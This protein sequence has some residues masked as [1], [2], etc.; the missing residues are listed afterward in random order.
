VLDDPDWWAGKSRFTGTYGNFPSA[1]VEVMY[2]RTVHSDKIRSVGSK[3]GGGEGR[4]SGRDQEE[5]YADPILPDHAPSPTHETGDVQEEILRLLRE[6]NENA[7]GKRPLPDPKVKP[8][9]PR[10][11]NRNPTYAESEIDTIRPEDS[12]SMVGVDQPP[13]QAP[14]IFGVMNVPQFHSQQQQQQH[15][16]YAQNGM[17]M[18][19]LPPRPMPALP[20]QQQHMSRPGERL[21][22]F[23][24]NAIPFPQ[25][26]RSQG[27][28]VPQNILPP[29][30]A[31][32][33][34]MQR[35]DSPP[36][37]ALQPFGSGAR[38]ANTVAQNNSHAN[39]AYAQQNQQWQVQSRL[40]AGAS[41][42]AFASEI[43][44]HTQIP[45]NRMQM[46]PLPVP[47]QPGVYMVPSHSQPPPRAPAPS[48]RPAPQSTMAYMN[49]APLPSNSAPDASMHKPSNPITP[50][51]LPDHSQEEA[52]LQL[53]YT[54]SFDQAS[55][56][57]QHSQ[58]PP[59]PPK[60][61]NNLQIMRPPTQR[62]FSL[63]PG[64]PYMQQNVQRVDV[65]VFGSG[66]FYP[67]PML[68][69]MHTHQR[70]GSLPPMAPPPYNNYPAPPMSMS[71]MAYASSIGPQSSYASQ[72]VILQQPPPSQQGK[73]EEPPQEK[74]P[75][76]PSSN[77]VP[78]IVPRIDGKGPFEVIEQCK[79]VKDAQAV[80]INFLAVDF[81]SV[82]KYARTLKGMD[83]SSPDSFAQK[84]VT[85][86]FKSDLE[87]V[88]CIF[89]WMAESI[90][91]DLK[92][93]KKAHS[94]FG[95]GN[96]GVKESKDKGMEEE[97]AL[98]VL[99]KRKCKRDGWAN[100]F[101]SI[102][103]TAGIKSSLVHGFVKGSKDDLENNQAHEANHSWNVGMHFV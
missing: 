4:R 93:D 60:P 52:S 51:D 50:N 45:S 54:K 48:Y 97:S 79:N 85:A 84:H 22:N 76:G 33:H 102:A 42:A 67:N 41:P 47:Q 99:R 18:P 75:A 94:W 17:M 53:P 32:K 10:P 29:P 95:F 73:S 20:Q 26:T 68:H 23:E 34:A 3:G 81:G 56:H 57:S 7:D 80:G 83:F 86:R 38:N 74:Q 88:R 98:N 15:M 92:P 101:Q 69:A 66:Q 77:G 49:A 12:I 59:T 96:G 91:W 62:P 21:R 28:A 61:P 36:I 39:S 19:V 9:P 46:R 64:E 63:P 25:P 8:P 43:H 24:M 100:L 78:W 13:P 6:S 44:A 40:L 71:A 65:P 30:G 70:Q 82:D 90:V 37:A 87:R 35:Q 14:N 89:V 16:M 2:A 31:P 5:V 11:G 58:P 55:V 103:T 27:G 72:T 1:L